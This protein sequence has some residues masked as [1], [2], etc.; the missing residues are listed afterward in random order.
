MDG[1]LSSSGVGTESIDDVSLS[2]RVTRMTILVVLVCGCVWVMKLSAL[3]HYAGD[4]DLSFGDVTAICQTMG[5]ETE[6]ED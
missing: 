5:L 1:A 2:K 4:C 3:S 6:K